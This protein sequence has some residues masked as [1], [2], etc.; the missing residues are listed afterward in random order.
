[1]RVAAASSARYACF[2]Q[3]SADHLVERNE[4]L[5]A[6]VTQGGAAYTLIHVAGVGKRQSAVDWQGRNGHACD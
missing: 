5:S 2:K 3:R 4:P 1:M 6:A